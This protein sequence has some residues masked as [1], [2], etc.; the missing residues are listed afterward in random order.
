VGTFLASAAGL[1]GP[2]LPSPQTSILVTAVTAS[3]KARA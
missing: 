2:T 1:S 3:P